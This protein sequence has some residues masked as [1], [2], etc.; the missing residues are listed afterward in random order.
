MGGSEDVGVGGSEGGSDSGVGGS[1]GV[2]VGGSEGGSDSGVGG[3]DSGVG[4]S[5]GDWVGSQ[6]IYRK[7]I[8]NKKHISTV[9]RMFK[10]I[11]RIQQTSCEQQ[12]SVRKR[13]DSLQFRQETRRGYRSVLPE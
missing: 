11:I 8:G 12:A 5:E 2:G 7:T 4:G 13:N 10:I 3:S 1:E 9:S 6:N